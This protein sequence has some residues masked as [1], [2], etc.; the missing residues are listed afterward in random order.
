MH[1]CFGWIRQQEGSFIQFL[2][3]TSSHLSVRFKHHIVILLSEKYGHSSFSGPATTNHCSFLVLVNE[4]KS[5]YIITG[6]WPM[7]HNN[8]ALHSSK[9]CGTEIRT[10]VFME[11]SVAAFN[12]GL[13]IWT[14]SIT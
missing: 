4:L 1:T 8:T 12:K 2:G 6:F 14:A 3:R 9:F 13:V 5:I 7:F 11:R 10:R